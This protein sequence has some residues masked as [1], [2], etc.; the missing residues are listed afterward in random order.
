MLAEDKV[1][2]RLAKRC[3]KRLPRSALVIYD[4]ESLFNEGWVVCL[5]C[6]EKFNPS[7]NVEFST[8]LW[9][10]LV[11]RYSNILRD[12]RRRHQNSVRY[13]KHFKST[14]HCG[15]DV[16]DPERQMI[17]SEAI[18]LLAESSKELSMVIIDGIPKELFYILR[19]E[20]RKR[21]KEDG[22]TATEGFYRMK[23][24]IISK[25]FNVN[26]A[27]IKPSVYNI[28]EPIIKMRGDLKMDK[29]KSVVELKK[30]GKEVNLML[31]DGENL[32]KFQERILDA[33][34]QLDDV[35]WDKLSEDIQGWA[36]SF[37][38]GNGT[39]VET[40]PEKKEEK[41]LEKKKEV[42]KKAVKIKGKKDFTNARK[43][44][45]KD[46]IGDIA[47][48]IVRKAGA[49]GISSETLAKKVFD[50]MKAKKISLKAGA[51]AEN[52]SRR[53]QWVMEDASP[54]GITSH[55]GLVEIKVLEAGKKWNQKCKYTY[56]GSEV[57]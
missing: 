56:Q 1:I 19:R 27:E 35:G 36:N 5:K 32:I 24:K 22:K 53:T 12:E 48:G 2:G 11:W 52:V 47:L 29:K 45:K 41:E 37:S 26:L 44:F 10:A 3:Y 16:N 13:K 6:K 8:Y 42:A 17:I 51:T 39:K 15:I 40:E 57:N 4:Y 31:E 34:D 9:T 55:N 33:V 46:T 18:Q 49:K 7:I 50:I 28:I 23:R 54:V 14:H 43:P 38:D 20:M 30:Y 25:F 21:M